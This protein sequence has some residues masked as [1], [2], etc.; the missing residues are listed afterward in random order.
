MNAI[1]DLQDF[2][3]VF[4]R[5]SA[6]IMV[7]PGLS[8]AQIPMRIR[9][10]A[11]VALSIAVYMLVDPNLNRDASSVSSELFGLIV[12][13]MIIGVSLALPLRFLFL[14][15]T[16]LGEIIVQYIGLN[17]IPGTPIGDDQ[18]TTTLSAL[19]NVT[20]VVLLVSTGMLEG[21]VIALA[22]SYS[23]FPAGGVF[24]ATEFLGFLVTQLDEFFEIMLR[25][26][27]PIIIYAV[28]LNML[29][30]MVNKLTPQV[31]I[32]F[33]STPFLICGGLV[34]LTW[35]GDDIMYLFSVE[36]DKLIA[37]P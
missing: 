9:L 27:S 20:A 11:A 2:L 31:P 30:G 34:M 23:V 26:G 8:M 21:Y 6:C 25:L 22:N 16:F 19:F 15:L 37:N 32:Y 24:A 17:P 1:V 35:I 4:V 10:Y 14:G 12:H 33:V 36:V 3:L 13:E 7:L 18:A 29:A 5:T 28:V